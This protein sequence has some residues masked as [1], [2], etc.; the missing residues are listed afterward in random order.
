MEHQAMESIED[1][2]KAREKLNRLRNIL[3]R[4]M[5]SGGLD[6]PAIECFLRGVEDAHRRGVWPN[7]WARWG[8]ELLEVFADELVEPRS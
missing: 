2:R 7:N 6:S 3:F 1:L 5:G 8:R 4:D